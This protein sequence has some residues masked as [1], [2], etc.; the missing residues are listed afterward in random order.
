MSEVKLLEAIERHSRHACAEE[1]ELP[2]LLL[3]QLLE[4]LP[5]P[6][7]ESVSRAKFP[8]VLS[9]LAPV[10]HID[11]GGASHD[12]SKLIYVKD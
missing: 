2:E 12:K 7:D 6:I 1:K 4:N 9:V 11:V 5:E 3:V 10:L 8:S